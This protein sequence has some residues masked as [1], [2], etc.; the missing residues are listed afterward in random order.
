MQSLMITKWSSTFF[1]RSLI[2]SR[3]HS[4][5]LW[6]QPIVKSEYACLKEW[7]VSFLSMDEKNSDCSVFDYVCN[8]TNNFFASSTQVKK[9]IRR[10]LILLND[11]KTSTSTNVS[12]GDV[13]KYI[14]RS[15]VDTLSNS[16][17]TTN[18]TSAN[19]VAKP[20]LSKCSVVWEDE[21]V[22]VVFKPQGVPMFNTRA[23]NTS[24]TSGKEVD[25]LPTNHSS[26]IEPLV[27]PHIEQSLHSLLLTQLSPA[28]QGPL[29]QPLRR[30]RLVHRLDQ[31]TF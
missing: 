25:D 27:E 9:S 7:N 30:P 15:G 21:Y 8:R 24:R 1:S 3:R 6:T 2:Q 10:G 20:D 11:N 26:L 14:V 16:I 18:D 31:G 19:L 17:L 28:A 13:I 23:N 29:A 12:S 22:A 5:T 4:F